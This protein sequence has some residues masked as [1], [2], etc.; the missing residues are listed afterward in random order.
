[1]WLIKKHISHLC[2]EFKDILMEQTEKYLDYIKNEEESIIE[3]ILKNRM[4]QF[5][6][7]TFEAVRHERSLIILLSI[8]DPDILNLSKF[9]DHEITLI[10]NLLQK[11]YI[12]KG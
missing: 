1:M 11:K 3:G 10:K 12:S 8:T 5:F 6:T 9:T 4:E 7:P 2:L